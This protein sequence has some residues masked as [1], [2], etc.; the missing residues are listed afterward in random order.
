MKS[1]GFLLALMAAIAVSAE[2]TTCVGD[3]NDDFYVTID[4]L[5]VG[6]RIILGETPLSFCAV[7]DLDGSGDVTI[8]EVVRAVDAALFGCNTV[9]PTST[10]TPSATSTETP[11]GPASATP[12][13]TSTPTV[14]ATP[15]LQICSADLLQVA[16]VTSPT[17]HLT[18]TIHLASSVPG[19]YVTVSLR[20][21][22]A[23]AYVN[24]RDAELP[25]Q[26]DLLFPLFAGRTT[27]IDACFQA[28]SCQGLAC[29]HSDSAGNP[30]EIVQMVPTARPAFQTVTPTPSL[31]ATSMSSQGTPTPTAVDCGVHQ[32]IVGVVESP[33]S[34][35]AATVSGY[36]L[37]VGPYDYIETCS[38]A[39]CS[40][41][42][43]RGSVMYYAPFLI[44]VPLQANSSNP[45]EVCMWDNCGGRAC[46]RAAV[47]GEPLIVEQLG[48]E[49]TPTLSAQFVD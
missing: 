1:L 4:E 11:G 44:E 40:D 34:E 10:P 21:G 7:Y 19:S 5:V 30:L 47:N 26:F 45:I 23:L 20:S 12:T 2:A 32:P 3:C 42:P 15:T 9:I 13:V 25:Q 33:T 31:T 16:P 27:E 48:V 37:V 36:A 24:Y 39:G 22:G 38:P 6:V 43:L 29:T 18:Q 28:T 46:Q 49:P 35:I 14:S 8:D 41:F 17:D